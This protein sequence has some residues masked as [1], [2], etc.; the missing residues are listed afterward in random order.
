M[1]VKGKGGKHRAVPLSFEGRKV[2]FKWKQRSK[3]DHVLATRNGTLPTQR[4]VGRDF[5]L[6][7]E[8]A[9]I[10]GVRFSP[11]LSQLIKQESGQSERG[12]VQG[13]DSTLRP[14]SSP[15]V[16]GD[17]ASPKKHKAACSRLR[18]ATRRRNYCEAA[19]TKCIWDANLRRDLNGSDD[20]DVSE[21]EVDRVSAGYKIVNVAQGK[22]ITP[23]SKSEENTIDDCRADGLAETGH[24]TA[25]PVIAPTIHKY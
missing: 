15:S 20:G 17:E 1:K 18:N 11:H 23:I 21:M 13:S 16:E 14:S 5:S 8:R 25:G 24:R 9:G 12:T 22:G 7:G 19:G 10:R 3:F 2:L 6:L 4:N